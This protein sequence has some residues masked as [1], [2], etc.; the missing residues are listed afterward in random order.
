MKVHIGLPR[1]VL[2]Y[3][4]FLPTLCALDMLKEYIMYLDFFASRYKMMNDPYLQNL[5]RMQTKIEI[6]NFNFMDFK[7][8]F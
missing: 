5:K 3:Y 8:F 7:D 1:S 2:A 6:L 4:A